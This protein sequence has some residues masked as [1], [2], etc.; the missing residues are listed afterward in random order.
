MAIK[1]VHLIFRGIQEQFSSGFLPWTRSYKTY[2]GIKLEYLF[3]EFYAGI[4]NLKKIPIK[5]FTLDLKS[6]Y[7]RIVD[8]RLILFWNFYAAQSNVKYD[9]TKIQNRYSVTLLK[10]QKFD[11]FGTC[12]DDCSSMSSFYLIYKH[13]IYGK[14]TSGICHLLS[15]VLF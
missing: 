1:I 12:A 5:L 8:F 2:F 4:F 15:L 3:I 14:P 6:F 10:N 7:A 9:Y 13:L 11:W